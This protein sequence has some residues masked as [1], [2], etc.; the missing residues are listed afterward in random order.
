MTFN[1]FDLVGI[2][3]LNLFGY[4]YLNKRN[5]SLTTTKKLIVS[6]CFGSI[7]MLMTGG[8]E[9]IRQNHCISGLSS[10]SDLSAY[11]Q[12]PSR[13]VMGLSQLFGLLAILEFTCFIAPRSAR[14]IFFSLY[15]VSRTIAN[16]SVQLV[17]MIIE[18]NNY[19]LKF[20]V[21][22]NC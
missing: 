11:V 3:F 17:V 6:M 19:D 8:T 21:E 9:I 20:K 15:F 7:G 4:K 10:L 2:L 12:V 16:Y 1:S 22:N 13:I 5:F 14:S 18:K